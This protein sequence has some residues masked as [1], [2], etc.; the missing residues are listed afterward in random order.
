MWRP[1]RATVVATVLLGIAFGAVVAA[2]MQGWWGLPR[3]ADPAMVWV[4]VAFVILTVCYVVV[5][6][7][8]CR[9]VLTDTTVE[10]RAVRT[11]PV[12]LTDIVAIDP[13]RLGLRITRRNLSTR[14]VLAL[15]FPTSRPAT[16][17]GRRTRAEDIGLTIMDRVT[18]RDPD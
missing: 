13:G 11:H 9:I 7:A 17:V 5:V 8:W 6:G 16:W 10:V 3:P 12:R 4:I 18:N 2:L 1:Q 14:S 15:G